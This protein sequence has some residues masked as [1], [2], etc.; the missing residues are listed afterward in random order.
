M[1]VPSSAFAAPA[2]K[3]WSAGSSIYAQIDR[4]PPG[5]KG[6]LLQVP[7]TFY[8]VIGLTLGSGVGKSDR[9]E[10]GGSS[11]TLSVGGLLPGPYDVHL[12]CLHPG[13][14]VLI[15]TTRRVSVGGLS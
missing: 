3:V 7:P 10:T 5:A 15:S 13:H 11:L 2:V 1:L 12:N 8:D 4:M 14:P 9:R 6:C